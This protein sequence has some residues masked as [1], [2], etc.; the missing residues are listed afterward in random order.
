MSSY[1]RHTVLPVAFAS[2]DTANPC[3]LSNAT[4]QRMLFFG[5][6]C[7]GFADGWREE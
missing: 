7:G 4:A 1:R 2:L 5:L 3:P 6:D